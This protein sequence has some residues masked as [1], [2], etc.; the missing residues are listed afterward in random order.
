MLF[1][2]DLN[3]SCLIHVVHGLSVL[4]RSNSCSPSHLSS[5]FFAWFSNLHLIL[6]A[7]LPKFLCSVVFFTVSIF[8]VAISSL[9]FGN[10][11]LRTS[12][13]HLCVS[14]H[15]YNGWDSLFSLVHRKHFPPPCNPS[16]LSLFPDSQPEPWYA[17]SYFHSAAGYV[18]PSSQR[19]FQ[20]Q[21]TANVGTIKVM[22]TL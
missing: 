16:S 17:T 9:I 19:C 7:I 3:S 21:N 15:F 13:L 1:F 5:L 2:Y 14:G 12:S 10:F 11:L 22:L 6:Y 18:G 8:L 20:S 4:H